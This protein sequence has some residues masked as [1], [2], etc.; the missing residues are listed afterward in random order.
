LP[1]WILKTSRSSHKLSRGTA[2]LLIL[3]M[4]KSVLDAKKQTSDATHR[5]A[6]ARSP[7]RRRTSSHLTGSGVM[8]EATLNEPLMADG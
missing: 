5:V 7:A 3:P 1:D 4:P 8:S 2:A 6:D